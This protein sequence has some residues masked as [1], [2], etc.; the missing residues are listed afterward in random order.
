MKWVG[1][2]IS[3][4][5]SVLYGALLGDP[6][7]ATLLSDDAEIAAM[8]RA[9]AALARVEARLG[10]IPREAGEAI[11]IALEGQTLTPHQL[12]PGMA[13]DGVG[14]P[15]LV[16]ELKKNLPPDLAQWLH[17]GATSQD[18]ADL[19]LVL[20]LKDVLD[21]MEHRLNSL[22]VALA[23]LAQTHRATLCLAR[24]RTQVAA[25]TLFGLRVTHWLA[26]LLRHRERLHQM[27]P[28]L[29]AVQL[30]GATGT[31]SALGIHG[32]DV[33]DGLADAL[34]LSRA[35]PWHNGRD[36]IEEFAGFLAMLSGTLGKMG[37]DLTILA[38][39]EI[40]EI[41]FAG[42][43]G[44]S[45]LPQKQNP[46]VAELLIALARFVATQTS[47]IHHAAIHANERDGAAWTL[48]WLTL[49]PMIAA[50]GVLL[51]KSTEALMALQ[52]DDKRMR[53]NLE[54][55][56]GLVL[57]EAASFALTAH[58]PRE[59]AVALVKSGVSAAL[60][61][62]RHLFEELADLT[63]APVDWAGLREPLSYLASASAL[64]D[65]VLAQARL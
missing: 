9:E 28:R 55:T 8:I 40:G 41:S 45:T 53:A 4:L 24:T 56:Q 43:G 33:M 48:E 31:L 44:S 1:M 14:T 16:A 52:V 5:D 36:R 11:A 6:E 10:V 64:M 51:I 26:P 47:G 18:I 50:S 58:M 21:I 42:A 60:A 7:I 23:E 19:S 34:G 20:R 2:A 22:I 49:P 54:A 29:L 35:L 3:P 57:S 62:G 65:R 12:A 46:V 39:S 59:K 61:S 30:G 37:A 63:P 15:A 25:P 13:R 27:R 32:L 38:Q 17:W